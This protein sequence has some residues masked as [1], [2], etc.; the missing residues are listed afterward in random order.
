[1][2]KNMTELEK[3]MNKNYA[4]NWEYAQVMCTNLINMWRELDA[5]RTS[6]QDSWQESY[7]AWSG[8]RSDD[9]KNYDGMADL[10]VPQ[11]RKE[12]ETMT[13]RLFKGLFP[14]DYLQGVAKEMQD[15]E[16]AITNTQLVR[17]YYDNIIK[18]KQPAYPWLK[19]GVLY[20]TSPIRQWWKKDISDKLFRKREPYLDKGEIK[21]RYKVVN[22]P[23]TNYNAPYLRACD[24]FET[25]IYPHNAQFPSE[26]EATFHR[27]KVQRS[28]LEERKKLGMCVNLEHLPSEGRTTDFAFEE[29]QERMAQFGESGLLLTP[30]PKDGYYDFLEVWIKMKLPDSTVKT[31][32][33]VEIVDESVCTRIQ[34][35]PYWHGESPFD[36][37]R[38]IIPPAGEFWGRGL[39]EAGLSLQNQLNDTMNQTMDATT[40]SLNNITIINPAYAPN[41]ESFEVEPGAIWW[42]DPNAVK[43]FTFPDLSQS[44]Y[45][46]AQAL[47]QMISEMSD[48]QPQ[49]PDPIAGKARSTGQAQLA[50]NEWQ[51]DLYTIIDSIGAEALSSMAYKTHALVQQNVEE[52]DVIKITGKYASKWI[53]K[54]ITPHDIV[55]RYEFKW[56]PSL[57]IENQAVKT[58]QM[59]NFPRVWA[60][61]PPEERA[62]VRLNWENWLIKLFRDGFLIKDVHTIVESDRMTA[63]IPPEIE[64]KICLKGGEIEVQKSDQDDLHIQSHQAQIQALDPKKNAYEIFKLSRHITKHEMQL[65]QKQR[66]MQ[67]MQMQMQMMQAQAGGG[68]P[69]GGRPE[70]NPGQIPESTS[71]D[72][73]EK[74]QKIETT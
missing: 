4:S 60:Q 61:L 5:Q 40:L 12:V 71:Q 62:N 59:L 37:M 45:R 57:Q 15:E 42:A 30:D 51:T 58:Q 21:F 50:V 19:Q 36:F 43:Q 23:V 24:L 69:Q 9:D 56:I 3:K 22:E 13:R 54:V 39:P 41:S 73:L 17:H 2:S 47:R 1:M 31:M 8:G 25:W 27:T 46:A 20:G 52:D 65:E 68:A 64:N 48:N 55:G 29:S 11:L 38:F 14:E 67:M 53:T 49:L 28:F 35:N 66:E 18:I 32:C 33:V 7:R 63:S 16:L 74:G 44:G 34:R 72:A 10:E 70:G 6:R 26:I